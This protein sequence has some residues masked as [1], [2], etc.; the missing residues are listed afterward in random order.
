M[1][2]KETGILRDHAE[3]VLGHVVGSKVERIYDHKAE[4][5]AALARLVGR[6]VSP[7]D[8]DKVVELAQHRA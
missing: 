4:A 6:I 1:S 5:L 3:R 2:R 7:P 8:D